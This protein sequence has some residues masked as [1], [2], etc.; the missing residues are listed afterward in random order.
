M[1]AIAKYKIV[2]FTQN[3]ST[4]DEVKQIGHSSI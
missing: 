3:F 1:R 4:F 2:F